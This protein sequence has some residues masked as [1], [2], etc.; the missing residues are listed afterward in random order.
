MS[1][2]NV[3]DRYRG[4]LLGGAIG[5]SLGYNVEFK[6]TDE[7]KKEFGRNGITDL[8]MDKSLKAAI[9]SD[10]TQ[11]TLFTAEGLL[12]A[13]ALGGKTGLSN[14]TTYVFY[15]YQRWLYTQINMIASREYM[16]VLNDEK[17]AYKSKLMRLE[18][19]YAQRAPGATCLSALRGA[20][21]HNYGKIINKIND[22]KGCGGV[23]RTAPAGLYFCRDSERAFRMGAEFAAITHTHPCG[24]LS[25]GVL[26]AII[27]ELVN[28]S[29]LRE[30]IDV[31]MYIL[32]GYDSCIECYQALEKAIALDEND[33][34]PLE[35]V[36]RLGSGFTGEEAISVAVYCAL[37]HEDNLKNAILLAANHDG[38]SDSTAAIC[39][40]IVGAHLG[41]SAIPK[42]WQKNIQ[43]GSTILEIADELYEC[44]KSERF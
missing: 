33:T 27:C 13:D 40:N 26:A 1:A 21:N 5:D 9:I 30:A 38:D 11:M 15:S 43:F 35:A 36:K 4:C 32:K 18:G 17:E 41:M 25:G 39:G 37:V 16:S 7:I 14:Y 2:H 6:S 44:T 20:A 42:K 24:Y 3:L 31:A 29:E 8:K 12:W 34:A 28:G 22:S 10:D 19:M 23:M